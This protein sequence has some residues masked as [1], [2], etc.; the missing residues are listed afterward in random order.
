MSANDSGYPIWP[1]AF[2]ADRANTVKVLREIADRLEKGELA[3]EGGDVSTRSRIEEFMTM[4]INLTVSDI[5]SISRQNP[6]VSPRNN[7]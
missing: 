7:S 4:V 3:L 6:R 5:D 1:Y 2:G